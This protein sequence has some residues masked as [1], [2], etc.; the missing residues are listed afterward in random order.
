MATFY[1]WPK[2]LKTWALWQRLQTMWRTSVAWR[3]GLDWASVTAWLRHAERMR[4]KQVARTLQVLR[5]MEAAALDVWA[6]EREKQQNK[7]G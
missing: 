4:T 3:D 5:T 2:S 6:A 7:K 1:I